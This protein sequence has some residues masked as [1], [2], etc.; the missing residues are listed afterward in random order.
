VGVV[1]IIRRMAGHRVLTCSLVLSITVALAALAGSGSPGG[2]PRGGTEAANDP[3]GGWRPASELAGSAKR[4]AIRPRVVSASG[5]PRT[6]PAPSA[7]RLSAERVRE[8]TEMRSAGGKVFELA[9]GRLQREYSATP[10]HYRSR[11]GSWQP[12]D[13]NVASS[14]RRGFVFGN[15]TNTF[16][17]FFGTDPEGL[18]LF[19]TGD[20]AVTLGVPQARVGRPA[21]D[22]SHVRYPD[23]W[24]PGVDLS[25]DVTA[26]ALK[27]KILLASRPDGAGDLSLRFTL[28]VRGLRVSQRTDGAIVFARTDDGPPVL[29]MPRP[30]MM[31]NADDA[32][33]PYAKA[34][35]DHVS[36]SV[37]GDGSRLTLTVR[38]DGRWLADPGRRYPVV[39]DPTI[40][41]APMPTDSQDTMILSDT[42]D[43]NYDTSWRL[44]VGTTVTGV[45][46]SLLRFPLT[47]IPAGTQIE[48][49]ALQLHYDQH[50]T[51]NAQAV[52]VEAH[53]ATAAWDETTATWNNASG[54]V[55]ELGNNTEEVDDGDFWQTAANGTW[56][57]ATASD[58]SLAVNS[59]YAYNNNTTTGETYAWYPII[60]E[61]GT[62]RVQVHY[63]AGPDRAMNAP[64]TVNHQ[65]GS[66]AYTVNQSATSASGVWRTLGSH[67][68]AP[69]TAGN[70][71]V[72]NVGDATKKVVADAIR[73]VKDAT[74]VRPAGDEGSHWHSF[75]VRSIVQG[76][77]NGTNPNYG[78]VVKAAD[79]VTKNMGGPRYEGSIYAYNGETAIYPR[80]VVTYGRPGV[81][82]NP[83]TTIYSTGAALGWSSYVDPCGFCPDDDIVEYQVHRSVF[84][85]FTP[86]AATLVAPVPVT[87]LSYT[88]TTAVPTPADDP[89]P[90]GNAYYYM[91]AVKTKDGGITPGPTQL[92]RLP[93]AGRTT[94]IFQSGVVDTTMSSSLPDSNLDRLDGQAWLSVGN[95]S[96]TYGRTR[97]VV[98]FPVAGIS[99]T[100]QVMDAQVKL[101]TAGVIGDGNAVWELHGLTRD[102]TETQATWNR[103]NSTTAWTTPG[104]DFTAAVTGSGTNF[105]NDPKRHN[106]DAT[107]LARGWVADPA[108]NKG[109]LVKLANEST[110]ASRAVFL[111]SEADEPELG[112]QLVVTYLDQTPE[113][114][115]YVPGT[116]PAVAPDS[117]TTMAATVTNTTT[118]TLTKADWALSYRWTRA[119]GTAVTAP[120]LQTALPADLASGGTVTVQAQV[121]APPAST[122]GNK[123]VEH[124][125][126]WD[127]FN[128][129]SGKWLSTGG[130]V[131]TVGA[132]K[133]SL[134][135]EESTSDQVGLESFYSYAG[136]NTGANSSLMNNLHAG[137]L[138][139]SYNAFTNPSRGVATFVRLAYNSKDT[140]D[141]V[142]GFGWSVQTSSVMRLGTPIDPH[143]NTQGRTVSL[144]DGDGTTHIF[145]LDDKGTADPGDDEYLHPA[146]VHLFLQRL[147]DCKPKDEVS[148][149]WVMT[150]PDRTQFYF[151]CAGYQT[152]VVDNNGNQ[153]NFVYEARRSNNEP[154]E[155]LRQL[156]DPI[157]RQSL[158]VDYYAKGDAY[159]YIDDVSWTRK[160]AT[161]LTNPNIIDHVKAIR[162]VSGRALTFTY[163]DKGLLGELVDGA[164]S[165]QPKV[166]KFAYDMT[167]G[168]KNVK[169]IRVTDP[170]GGATSLA[171][172]SASTDDPKF[173]WSTKSILDRLGG[174]GSFAYTDPDGT[175]GQAVQTVVTDA[176]NHAA[177]YL[178][179][180]KGRP[181]QT[182]N[183]KNQ[184]IKLAWDA[185]NN[186]VRLEE[187]NAAVSTWT[188]DQN[189]GYPTETK[190]AEANN[191]AYQGTI[192]TYQRGLNGH[193]ADL[194]G[195]QSPEGR[196]WTFGYTTEG[197]LATVTDPAGSATSTA[198]DF[199]TSY[200]YDTWGQLLSATDA[201]GNT[202][203]Y[204]DFDPSGYP[205]RITDPQPQPSVTTFAYDVR[206]N[207]T[208]LTDALGKKTTQAYD[209]FGRPL[210]NKV[211]K[212]QAG[213]T[214]ITT[215]A[216]VYD[217]NDNVTRASAPNGAIT[218][219]VY[220]AADQLTSFL[221]PRQNSTDPERRGSFTY[222]KVGNLLT[223]TEPNGNLT[224]TA[225]DFTTSY[226]YDE[227]DELTAVTNAL[228]QKLSYVYDNAGNV[229]KVIDP[230]KNATTDTGD[231]TAAFWYDLNHRVRV[232]FDALGKVTITDYDRDGVVKAVTDKA[233]NTTEILTDV[234]GKPAQIKVPRVNN[235]GVITYRI[236]RYEYDQVGNRTKVI[237]PRGVATGSVLDDFVSQTVYD[238]LNRVK[239]QLTPYDPAD[240]R[241][242]KPDKT[243]FSYD[244][245]GRLTTVSA[246][247]SDG[248]TVRN[249]TTYTYFDNGWTRTSVDP[250]DIT[251]FYDYNELGEQK[252]RIIG[253]A[254]G[255]SSS[256]WMVWDYFADGALRSRADSGIGGQVVLVDNTD[257]NNARSTGAWA[258]SSAGT[259]YQ[260]YNYRTHA[261]GSGTDTFRWG[262][263]IP[264]DGNYDVYVRYPAVS[265][266][267]TNATYR[268][269]Y[270]GGAVDKPVNQSTGAGTWVNLGRFPFTAGNTANVT[271]SQNATGIVVADAVKLVR[272]S[273]GETDNE[274]TNFAYA[275]D[276]NGNL[277]TITDTSLNRRIDSYAVGY[278]PL[279]QVA[280]VEEIRNGTVQNTTSFTY[281]LNGAVETISHDRDY[282]RYEYDVRDLVAKVTNG[283]S[284]TDPTPKVTTFTYTDRAERLREVKG[285]GNTVD[286]TYYLDGL[287]N[288]Q[289]EKKP[290]G[291]LVSQ[292]TLGYD[293]NGNRTSD[294]AR[295]MNA[296]N[297]AAYLDTTSTYTY[298]P[299]DRIATLTRTGA[300]AGTESYIH[301]PNNNVVSQTVM[302]TTTNYNYE[303]NRLLT[304]VI[305]GVTASY[306]YDPFGRL[307]TVTTNNGQILERNIYDGFDH[308]IEHRAMSGGVTST[309]KY[310]YDPL[311]RT[312]SKTTDVGTAKEKTTSFTYLGLSNEI[313][314]E[315]VAASVT[316]SYQYSPWGERLS[317][318][319]R[320]PDGTEEAGYY[321]YNPHTDVETVTDQA[322][323]SKATYGYTAYGRNDDAQFTGVDKPDAADPTKEPYNPYRFN[324]KRW[325]QNSTTYDMG[326]R[327][328]SPGL[329][330]FLSRDMYNGALADMNLGVSPFTGS[331]YAFGFGNPISNIEFDGHI[332]LECTNG[333]LACSADSD[334][335]WQVFTR[336]QTELARAAG[337][338]DPDDCLL[339]CRPQ[340]N[341]E[342]DECELN[343]KS[344]YDE[345]DHRVASCLGGPLGFLR[346]MTNNCTR[347]DAEHDIVREFEDSVDE[348]REYLDAHPDLNELTRIAVEELAGNVASSNRWNR[349]TFDGNRVY[350]RDDYIDPNRVDAQGRTNLER[351]QSGR[352]PIGPD[353][354]PLQLHHLT[355]R[356][357]GAIAEI[358]QTLHQ[359]YSRILHINPSS[360]P[361][362]IDRAAFGAWR[363][364]YWMARAADFL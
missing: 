96:A 171:Y 359:Q 234:R 46:R 219:A 339:E 167:Q 235:A 31:D 57:Y 69:G 173:K 298:D 349:T 283:K 215:P 54:N 335:R 343:C 105:S 226:L 80:L 16:H 315:E 249:D 354:N 40:R 50:H 321:G 37:S 266:A 128:K 211:P 183:A 23:V 340:L 19:E 137:N 264:Q 109:V 2:T 44:S 361:S 311:D 104:G 259:G 116:P 245:V 192:L 206:G 228:G 362:G 185:D 307:D 304:A 55:G 233:G 296:D 187:P 68:F 64:Y 157:G 58:T 331:R 5:V 111:S 83:P 86:S 279:N 225:G 250:W 286:Y 209:A 337:V 322:G 350:Q 3:R 170:R 99:T 189:T 214:F 30:F 38:A 267:A 92:V 193:I 7:R 122:E 60:T 363:Q 141:S 79:E 272:D 240:A 85:T 198:G 84:Q 260:G 146:G 218:D 201:N 63:V 238:Q 358:T 118:Q 360:I 269:A 316:K 41:I 175:S 313:L 52:T 4:R 216:P 275:Y 199:T 197:D 231:Y 237:T 325:D 236:T 140:S 100:A 301:D 133:Q 191:N 190:D 341:F 14:T 176:N 160:P 303:R 103:A 6:D 71:V 28:A 281:N 107:A 293:L 106:L 194:I 119:D 289:I 165:A 274:S 282:A 174:L 261:A 345:V 208:E 247:P 74:A 168:N 186:V 162:D 101:W 232:E 299:R 242:N 29:V 72:G 290:G 268:I 93:K 139:W 243:T 221:I 12:I 355:Q 196:V 257:F 151:D 82:V 135:V 11:N 158:T 229:S 328:Y 202:T 256:R 300:G 203:G 113:S 241:Y 56:P 222:D 39:I 124:V 223:E 78:F 306:N 205:R 90:F 98:K 144:T 70:V 32:S 310:S 248:Q 318:V 324:A 110:P 342:T 33:S 21:V 353:G 121:Q 95:N 288:T 47:G 34:F 305:G 327:D 61:A 27:E 351:M 26:S 184:T 292:H 188:Y 115:Y 302:G 297:H 333:E 10:L 312:A 132:L 62:Y 347:E 227:I 348:L 43:A 329:N 276:P 112:P 213:G 102:F 181:T 53:R 131:N 230:R 326:F 295:K 153:M 129:T 217:A 120:Q 114:T 239:E 270:S 364:R 336:E 138:V 136:K 130:A 334:G 1:G 246:P 49:A 323:D 150:R 258:T 65:G 20:A 320:N 94:K 59:D 224:A 253:S 169:L 280:G 156:I 163:T 273:T 164:G 262:L 204:G 319:K 195:K 178:M 172:Y 48:S 22:G 291:T 317:Q 357:T 338:E 67:P 210:E 179:D 149:A 207:V 143:P 309:T 287:L 265:G 77:L 308:V 220:D 332:P 251:T 148:R 123:R 25:Y 42:A 18:V 66:T 252:V 285:N 314:N 255:N 145:T 284:A 200:T 87:T 91:V 277:R 278:T 152:S 180:G 154:T 166:F 147:V 15:E 76:W 126:S 51:T 182:T 263:N 75:S 352:A 24:G 73:V 244:A 97:A 330:R 9:D 89:D 35:S 17:S 159:D 294:V 177:T 271:L 108:S 134:A 117:V 356:Q 346:G 212:D 142:A 88:D 127:L 155:F 161:N 344:I 13:T 45:A 125:L 81:A 36:Q 8:L 254:G